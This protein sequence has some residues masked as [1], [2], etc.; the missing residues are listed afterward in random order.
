MAEDSPVLAAEK[1]LGEMPLGDQYVSI[2]NTE[3]RL[4]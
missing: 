2:F 3:S 1:V 4:E